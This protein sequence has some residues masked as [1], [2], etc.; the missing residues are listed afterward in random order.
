MCVCTVL[1]QFLAIDE[2]MMKCTS[3][4]C[5]FLQHMPRKPI[6][7]GIKAF[8]LG[9]SKWNYMYKWTICVGAEGAGYVYRLIYDELLGDSTFDNAGF[10][11][12]SR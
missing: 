10:S 12:S 5:P 1:H 9:D 6:K 4:Y 3:K 8:V 7:L 2:S 11:A